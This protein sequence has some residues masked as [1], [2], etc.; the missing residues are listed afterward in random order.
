DAHYLRPEDFKIHQAYLKSKEGDRETESFYE[1]CFVQTVDE[2]IERLG[3]NNNLSQ[4]E[5][6]EAINNT[7]TIGKM[8]E[9]YDLY[10]SPTIPR[11]QIPKFEVRHLFKKH[12]DKYEYIKLM[13][14]SKE[15]QDRY[16]IK[17]I[18]DGFEE[19]FPKDKLTEE[20]YHQ[21]LQRINMELEELWKISEALNQ[22]MSSYY[23]TVREIIN[24]IWDDDGGNSLVGIAR[25]SAAGFLINYLLGITQFN[26]M[27]YN[28]PHWRHLHHS[29]PDMP[30]ID[31]DTEGTKRQTILKALKE[32]FGERRVLNIATFGTEGSRSAIL[33]AC[34][35]LGID[36]DT[37]MH[38]AS[39]IPMER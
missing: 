23:I 25:G 6:E 17:L 32:R 28:L 1:S 26:P 29:R 10:R 34:R 2:I 39:L 8:V 14:T 9:D 33:T 4:Q 21:I 13:A 31:I 15:E 22:A 24:L 38:I 37:A 3:H 16:L 12:Y 5:I 18:E 19:K 7:M 36:N 27:D 30:D 35:G 20:Y 11:I